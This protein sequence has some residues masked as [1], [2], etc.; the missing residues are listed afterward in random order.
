MRLPEKFKFLETLQAF[1][2]D[3]LLSQTRFIPFHKLNLTEFWTSDE[4]LDDLEKQ[5]M[6]IRLCDWTNLG[7]DLKDQANFWCNVYNFKN[8]AGTC[9]FRTLAKLVLDKLCLPI[10][11]AYVERVFSQAALGLAKTKV[12]NKMGHKLLKSI[13]MIR[14]HLMLNNSCCKDFV[15]SEEMLN[16][17][18]S[19]SMYAHDTNEGDADTKE[20]DD[21]EL[22][23]EI[24][25]E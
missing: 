11:N 24:L 14:S 20:F 7:I 15:V 2:P 13:L 16:K 3:V 4:N 8:A 1:H 9:C 12:R 22:I 21:V 6:N 19:S 25:Q 5:Y 23:S 18:N 10:S 17:F